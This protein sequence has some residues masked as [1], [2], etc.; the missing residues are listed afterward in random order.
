LEIIRK[1]AG[2]GSTWPVRPHPLSAAFYVC[3]KNGVPFLFTVH[4]LIDLLAYIEENIEHFSAHATEYSQDAW[5]EAFDKARGDKQKTQSLA[6]TM[7]G[8][9]TRSLFSMVSKAIHA[10]NF[11]GQ[12]Y[13]DNRTVITPETVRRTIEALTKG[14]EQAVDNKAS[15]PNRP[16]QG[17]VAGA[18]SLL[19]SGPPGTGK[20]FMAD[21][22][23]HEAPDSVVMR[24]T[25]ASGTSHGDF[26]GQVDAPDF[27]F[28]PGPF[29]TAYAHAIGNPDRRVFLIIEEINRGNMNAI[30][31]EVFTMMDRD[32]SG[33]GR[34]GVT[35]QKALADW[36]TKATGQ[37]CDELRMPQNLWLLATK[38]SL[39]DS[40][41]PMDT[42]F[43]RRW[44]QVHL[45]V[46]Y[47]KVPDRDVRIVT[48]QGRD[49]SIAYREFLKRLNKYLLE[50]VG[51][52]EDRIIGP[53]FVPHHKIRGDGR[54]NWEIPGYL[55]DRLKNRKRELL[56]RSSIKTAGDAQAYLE[57]DRRIF[58]N[59]FLE[60]L[61]S[62][63][64][65][66]D[67][68]ED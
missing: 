48:G 36:V 57:Q 5:R 17:R 66:T 62:P 16:I 1:M 2:L 20:T 46:D 59:D 33:R 51:L 42:A 63:A 55:W 15:L 21:E 49:I 44:E 67:D 25:F 28:K 52:D 37:C 26:V 50:K 19:I 10:V 4:D 60:A 34:Y 6:W 23:A 22:I 35:P 27:D 14:T 53:Y 29:L 40:V 56:F 47:T 65:D 7:S 58:S 38:N 24:T 31:G 39:D 12:P 61:Q 41:H 43:V 8:N 54:L 68:D 11:E 45:R 3:N 18:T 32:P 30:F 64:A 9:Q 13:N